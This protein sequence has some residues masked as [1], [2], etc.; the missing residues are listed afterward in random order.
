MK[1]FTPTPESPICKDGDEW[2]K[3]EKRKPESHGCKPVVWGFTLIETMVVIAITAILAAL[4][5][6]YNRSSEKQIALFKDQAVVAGALDRAKAF[7]LER[8]K[9][10]TETACAFGVHIDATGVAGAP[11]TIF[12]DLPACNN[13]YDEPGEKLETLTLDPRIEF[14]EVTKQSILFRTP[15]LEVV[16]APPEGIQITLGIQG[17]SGAKTI[18]VGPGGD[19]NIR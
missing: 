18:S 19:I 12:Q 13:T 1:G 10:G 8:F 17:E 7:A 16:D 4:T 6:A 15:Y 14:R 5:I 9:S 3:N 11:F 2:S